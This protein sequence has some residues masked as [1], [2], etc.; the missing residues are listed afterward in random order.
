MLGGEV[1]LKVEGLRSN[2]LNWSRAVAPDFSNRT[3][4]LGLPCSIFKQP[5]NV[6]DKAQIDIPIR[7]I[8]SH[9]TGYEYLLEEAWHCADYLRSY[10]C[11][12]VREAAV[13]YEMSRSAAFKELASGEFV[14]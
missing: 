14:K 13:T 5:Q 8:D 10:A 3:S 9:Q 1:V 4:L 7:P 11:I 12:L 2:P 6:R